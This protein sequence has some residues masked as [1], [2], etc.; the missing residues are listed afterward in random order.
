MSFYADPLSAVHRSCAKD[1]R[2]S[3]YESAIRGWPRRQGKPDRA[4]SGHRRLGVMSF[5]SS[6]EL[7]GGLS[8]REA[9]VGP[10]ARPAEM[11]G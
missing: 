7:C 10:D 3:L 5:R 1:R 4:G 9:F 6:S 11:P 2:D 8:A